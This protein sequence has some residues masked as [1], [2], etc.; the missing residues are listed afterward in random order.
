M[1]NFFKTMT[2]RS[3]IGIILINQHVRSSTLILILIDF[4][5]DS[6]MTLPENYFIYVM[7]VISINIV[8]MGLYQ[9]Y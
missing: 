1:E 3:D 2:T 4:N 9:I 8:C 7:E 6:V 5:T